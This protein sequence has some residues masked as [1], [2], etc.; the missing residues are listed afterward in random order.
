[1]KNLAYIEWALGVDDYD[2]MHILTI[3]AQDR[4]VLGEKLHA[5]GGF[6][7]KDIRAY[8]YEAGRRKACIFLR[9]LRK[10]VRETSRDFANSNTQENRRKYEELL[11]LHKFRLGNQ[12]YL[13]EEGWKTYLSFSRSKL[14][15][16]IKDFDL[17]HVPQ[18]PREAFLE[19]MMDRLQGIVGMYGP[20]VWARAEF[21]KLK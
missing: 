17:R 10:K 4:E 15:D 11:K 16:K 9:N 2:E 1:L 7:E 19:R 8:D 12:V 6:F 3:T 5:F 20:G 21:M 14:P 13:P 18:E